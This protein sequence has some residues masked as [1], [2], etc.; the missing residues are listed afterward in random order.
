MFG[1][2][3][4]PGPAQSGGFFYMPR[5][6]REE[7]IFVSDKGGYLFSEF[8]K[9]LSQESGSEIPPNAL[10]HPD[11]AIN[12]YVRNYGLIAVIKDHEN[13]IVCYSASYLNRLPSAFT[14]QLRSLLRVVPDTEILWSDDVFKEPQ[15]ASAREVIYGQKLEKPP[16]RRTREQI[17]RTWAHPQALNKREL[18]FL[19]GKRD[20]P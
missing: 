6:T 20:E 1:K 16:G 17:R 19:S 14:D 13:R 5:L 15:Y 2:K 11:T 9:V 7:G 3:T 10:K 12:N 18:D 4:K 8:L